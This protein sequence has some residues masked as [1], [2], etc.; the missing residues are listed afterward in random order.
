MSH[1]M[2]YDGQTLKW[3]GNGSFKAT[4]GFRNDYTKENYQDP[5]YQCTPEKGPVPEGN[6]YIPVIEGKYA[7]DDGKGIC[8]L[9]PSWHI[10][11]IPRGEMAGPMCEPAWANWGFNRVRFV[12]ADQATKN[13]CQPTMRDGFYL[14]DSTKG[15]SHGCIEVEGKFFNIL[16]AY[17]KKSDDKRLKLKIQYVPGRSTNGGTKK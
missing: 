14:H 8:R 10:E 16:R 6:Y 9:N 11:K 2:L 1:D 5:S 13:V 4:S 12:A 3:T 7:K 15:F 17:I